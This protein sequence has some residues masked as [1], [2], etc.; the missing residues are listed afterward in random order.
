MKEFIIDSFKWM[1]EGV[2]MTLILIASFIWIV[3][4]AALVLVPSTFIVI[5]VI[6]FAVKASAYLFG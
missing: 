5:G 2:Y 1:L 6:Y 4:L 3:I